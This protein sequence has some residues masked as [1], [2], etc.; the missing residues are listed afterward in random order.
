MPAPVHELPDSIVLT[1]E[2]YRLVHAGL[3][4]CVMRSTGSRASMPT[5]TCAA[6]SKLHC[7][8]CY[9]GMAVPR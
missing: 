6:K 4:A 8:C 3:E 2:E 1:R 5:A 7:S 9:V